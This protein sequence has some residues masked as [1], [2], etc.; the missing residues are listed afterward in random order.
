MKQQF[1]NHGVAKVQFRILAL[2]ASLLAIETN[3]IRRNFLSWMEANF[4]LTTSQKFQ[5][6]TMPD[7]LQDTLSQAIANSYELGQAV[8]FFKETTSKDDQP[9]LKD[10]VINGAETMAELNNT[11]RT[12]AFVGQLAINIRYKVNM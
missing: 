10:I 9:D 7:D 12:A 2:P 11:S 3:A 5:L 4:A 8:Q 6:M 1:N